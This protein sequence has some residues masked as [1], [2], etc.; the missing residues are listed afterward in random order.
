VDRRDALDAVL[1]I[2]S[3]QGGYLTA[4]QATRL[5]LSRDDIARLVASGDLQRARR[6]VF[7]MRHA[8]T[9]HEDD[10]A[11]WLHFEG[12]RLPWERHDATNV[13][14]SHTSAAALHQLGSVIPQHP[15]V[16]LSPESTRTPRPQGITVRRAPLRSEDWAWIDVDG[17]RLPVTT[18][19][20][21]VVDLL[22]D[23]EEPSYVQRAMGEALAS[24]RATPAEILDAAAH[25]RAR[26]R[27][28]EATTATLLK[29]FS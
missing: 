12:G 28:L 23:R 25:R 10:V 27:E 18:P 26:T 21:T 5:G 7:R 24:G 3:E 1:E 17:L 4:A 8:Q 9:R 20:R 14:I 2:A 29:A 16:T 15:T 19:A 22:A 11:A 13:V 6:G